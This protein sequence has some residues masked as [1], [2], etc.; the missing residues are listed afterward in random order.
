MKFEDIIYEKKNGI[1]RVTINRPE[2][3]NAFRTETL[4]EL[5][6][7][8]EDIGIDRTIGVAVLRGAGNRA[9]C[10]GGDAGESKDAGY[11][12]ELIIY[13]RKVHD[14]IRKVPV[15]V[16]AAVNGYAIGG[17]HVFQVLCDLTIA[18]ENAIFGQAGPKVGSFDAGYGTAYLARVVGEKKARE[19]WFLCEQYSAQEA[20][21]MG[22]VNKIVPADRL[23]EEVD[24]WC[25]KI[26][27][28][29]PTALRF[30]KASFNRESDH[31]TGSEKMAFEAM[32]LY[33]Q[34]E[35]AAEGK[36]AYLEKRGPD[37]SKYR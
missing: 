35:E 14:L 15:P 10:V 28:L 4:I 8:F 23:D 17:G 16:I 9:F 36:K 25:K 6:K 18:S 24:A 33:Y 31:I 12:P 5:V 29:G 30:L 11:R 13:V 20:K 32:A 22:L 2:K 1:A 7:A 19:I 34:T 37:F 21:E 27:S 3:L 26:L